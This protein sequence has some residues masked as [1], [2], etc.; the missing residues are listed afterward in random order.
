MQPSRH[1]THMCWAFLW[2]GGRS[3]TRQHPT[4]RA[5]RAITRQELMHYIQ[6]ARLQPPV[7]LATFS[8]TGFCPRHESD[9][10]LPP[11]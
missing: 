2:L 11:T 10:F 6:L 7:L 5:T 8:L 3:L 9:Y 4:K 1:V